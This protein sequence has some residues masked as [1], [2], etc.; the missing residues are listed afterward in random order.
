MHPLQ[1]TTDHGA[2]DNGRQCTGSYADLRIA[3]CGL[4]FLRYR[5]LRGRRAYAHRPCQDRAWSLRTT[6][7]PGETPPAGFGSGG[8]AAGLTPLLPRPPLERP[9]AADHPARARS[10]TKGIGSP[11]APVGRGGRHLPR[12]PPRRHSPPRLRCPH[13]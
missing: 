9:R 8:P 4:L 13:R 11:P 1:A 3:G 2:R 10:E 6:P 7:G 5:T 12:P